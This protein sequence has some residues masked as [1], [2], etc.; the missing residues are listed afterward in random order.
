M[1]FRW[2]SPLR[3]SFGLLVSLALL[4]T[5]SRLLDALYRRDH[6]APILYR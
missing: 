2:G 5:P 6:R 3:S 1:H 4:L